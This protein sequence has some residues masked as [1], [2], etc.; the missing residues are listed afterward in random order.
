MEFFNVLNSIDD[1][2]KFTIKMGESITFLDVCFKLNSLGGLV[3]LVTDIYYKPT[4]TH[5]YVPFGSFHPHKTLRGIPGR[6][7]PSYTTM[8]PILVIFGL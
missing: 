1:R 6:I 7:S 5:N 2:I 3:V 8:S 4:N